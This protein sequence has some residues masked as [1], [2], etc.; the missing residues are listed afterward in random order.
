M[1]TVI[2]YIMYFTRLAIVLLIGLNPAVSSILF[3]SASASTFFSILLVSFAIMNPMKN[4]MMAISIL[5][6]HCSIV[7]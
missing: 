6:S 4:I 2:M 1:N 7:M 5:V 3:I